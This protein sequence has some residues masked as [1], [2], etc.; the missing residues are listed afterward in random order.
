VAS[1]AL[2]L[3]VLLLAAPAARADSWRRPVDGPVLR[4]FALGADPY[5]RGQHRGVDL[6]APPRSPVRSACAGRVSFAGRVPGGGRTVSVRCGEI[7]AT[8]QQL[9]TIAARAGQRIA[10]GAPVGLVGRS[11]DPRTVRPHL[12]LGAREAA[13]GRYVDPLTLLRG[14]PPALPLL[15]PPRPTRPR[16]A[17][18]RGAPV[19]APPRALPLGPAPVPAPALPRGVPLGSAPAPARA[20]PRGV[21][22]GSAP[23][24]ARALPRG[25]PVGPVPVPVRAL[26]RGVPVGPVPASALPRDAAA[27]AA[28]S[29]APAPAGPARTLPWVVW[30][31]LASISLALP[32]GGIVTV[33][34][35][36]R[37]PPAHAVAT[38]R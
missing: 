27:L 8:Y 35:R 30:L 1:I 29:T 7:V 14:A 22:L 28:G 15:V 11:S 3:V 12:H 6:G 20:L 34:R 36:R 26:P 5:A 33:R 21:P 37:G 31:G 2:S 17:A 38:S 16:F 10:P 19:P 32:I 24:P 9:G 13:T 18:P 25:V 23:V 4:A